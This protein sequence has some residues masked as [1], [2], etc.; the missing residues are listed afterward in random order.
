VPTLLPLVI[1]VGYFQCSNQFYNA[2]GSSCYPFNVAFA[3]RYRFFKLTLSTFVTAEDMQSWLVT[4]E[5]LFCWKIS[6][7]DSRYCGEF[8]YAC[9]LLAGG[10]R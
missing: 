6:E 7:K 1:D 5:R 2:T 9:F 8:L 4:I 10:L 3:I